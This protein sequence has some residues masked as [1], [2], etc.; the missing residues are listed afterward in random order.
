M[1]NNQALNS[2]KSDKRQIG[3]LL[4][5]SGEME[6]ALQLFDWGYPPNTSNKD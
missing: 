4:N 1:S 6:R 5:E 2:R 3:E